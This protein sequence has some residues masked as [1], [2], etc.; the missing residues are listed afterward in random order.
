MTSVSQSMYIDKLHDIVTKYNNTYHS[1]TKMNHVDVKS[2][3]Y[4]EEAN[5]KKN[6]NKEIN[7]KNPSFKIGGIVRISKYKTIFAESLTPN[8]SK[9][10]FVIKKVKNPVNNND[11]YREK[12]L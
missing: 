5:K 4:I 1:T 6:K 11:V 10:V 2:S 7:D 12:L 9:E 3:T 8:W